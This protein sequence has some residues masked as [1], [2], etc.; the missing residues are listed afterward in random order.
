[1]T[2]SPTESCMWG[3]AMTLPEKNKHFNKSY[4]THHRS[5]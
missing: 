2:S 5:R 4:L 3:T 1:V